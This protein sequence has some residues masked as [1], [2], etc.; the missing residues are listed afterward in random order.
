MMLSGDTVQTAQALDRLRVMFEII[1]CIEGTQCHELEDIA[2]HIRRMF[3]LTLASHA[4]EFFEYV[5]KQ[6]DTY[7]IA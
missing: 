7:E 1:D 2:D 3:D 6:E 4:F 5:L